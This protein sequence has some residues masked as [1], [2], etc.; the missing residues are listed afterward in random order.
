VVR[1]IRVFVS[2]PD[3][4][5]SERAVL[6]E[7]VASINQTEGQSY[8]VRLELFKWEEHIVPQIGPGRQDVMDRQVPEYHIYLGIMSTKFGDP[9]GDHGCGTEKEFSDALKKWKQAD[10]PWITFYFD[11]QP[12]MT[13]D[14]E[15]AKQFTQVCE[16]RSSLE[17]MGIVATYTGARGSRGSFYE[18]V[19]EHLRKIVHRPERSTSSYQHARGPGWNFARRWRGWKAACSARLGIHLSRTELRPRESPG[20]RSGPAARSSCDSPR[21][22]SW[23]C[24]SS[25]RLGSPG[26]WPTAAHRRSL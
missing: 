18:K 14:P 19:S 24:S 17:K 10:T 23:R 16:F 7:V 21:G 4:V 25:C 26:L 3:D 2:S 20:C 5:M 8:G 9:T 6:D 22:S 12:K 15:Q 11:A 13:G 1:I